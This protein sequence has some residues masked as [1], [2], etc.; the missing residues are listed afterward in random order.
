MESTEHSN[1]GEDRNAE[2]GL[3][4]TFYYK[5]ASTTQKDVLAPAAS[6][7]TRRYF[8]LGKGFTNG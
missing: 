3:K 2:S 4:E 8:Q 1:F 6:I 7:F 5:E